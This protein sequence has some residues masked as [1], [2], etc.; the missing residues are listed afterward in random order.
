MLDYKFAASTALFV[1]ALTNIYISYSS[2]KDRDTKF[3]IRDIVIVALAF[4]GLITLG[5]LVH[6][7]Q[8][9]KE[10]GLGFCGGVLLSL[11]VYLI[12]RI[13]RLRRFRLT[14]R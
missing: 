2:G 4:S 9:S 10:F 12:H 13:F 5:F 8:P 7:F 3:R 6:Y 11:T 1:V 14:S